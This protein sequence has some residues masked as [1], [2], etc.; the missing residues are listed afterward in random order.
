MAG[1][2]CGQVNV[3]V[4][5]NSKIECEIIDSSDCTIVNRISPIL[6]NV[7]GGSLTEY[8]EK[9]DNKFVNI[10]IQIQTMQREIDSLKNRVQILES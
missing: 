3:P 5:D 2:V 4:P 9:L 1:K 10:G 8:L 7:P 6:R